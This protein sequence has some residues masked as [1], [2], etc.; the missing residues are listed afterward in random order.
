M[1]D[2]ILSLFFI[3]LFLVLGF[4]TVWINGL[5]DVIRRKNQQVQTDLDKAPKLWKDVQEPR[6]SKQR[7][8]L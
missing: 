6:S 1:R 5:G 7:S 4:V 2:L 3:P 8:R